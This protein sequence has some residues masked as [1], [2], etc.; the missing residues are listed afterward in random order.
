[1]GGKCRCRSYPAIADACPTIAGA[2]PTLKQKPLTK[3]SDS[4]TGTE[5]Q[6]VGIKHSRKNV[7][8][9]SVAAHTP[10]HPGKPRSP[11]TEGGAGDHA[12]T[13]TNNTAKSQQQ[14]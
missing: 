13:C 4:Q 8:A 9:K 3:A 5:T 14:K 11:N 1:M 7:E 2:C 6:A 12:C 10:Q